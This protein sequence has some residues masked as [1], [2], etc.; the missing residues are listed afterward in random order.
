MT[1]PESGAPR[2]ALADV[3]IGLG[4]ILAGAALFA[5]ARR[6]PPGFAFDPLGPAGFP[7]LLALGLIG[8][9]LAVA[10]QSFVPRRDETDPEPPPVA[11]SRLLGAVGV[12]IAYAVVLQPVGFLLSTPAYLASLLWL[13]GRVPAR[14]FL[15]T[16]VAFPVALFAAF[17]LLGVTLPLGVLEPLWLRLRYGG[18]L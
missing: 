4:L 17:Q 6:L 3:G 14:D 1:R 13:Q 5:A 11:S 12:S 7:T 9:G 15:L 16:V 10:V 8:S 2:R 18:T